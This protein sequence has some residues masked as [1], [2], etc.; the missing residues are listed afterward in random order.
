MKTPE[1]IVDGYDMSTFTE[2]QKSDYA[3][4]GILPGP[5]AWNNFSV[6]APTDYICTFEYVDRRPDHKKAGKYRTH[7]GVADLYLVRYSDGD[8]TV[9]LREDEQWEGSYGAV[10]MSTLISSQMQF[11]PYKQVMAILCRLGKFTWNPR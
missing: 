1:S 3:E 5:P 11:Q 10:G 9:L 6:C 2:Q 4:Y 8:C 7:F